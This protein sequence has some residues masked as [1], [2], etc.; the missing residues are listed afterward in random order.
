MIQLN[1]VLAFSQRTLV[2]GRNPGFPVLALNL[3]W[4]VLS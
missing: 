1:Q 4:N 2:R 3:S